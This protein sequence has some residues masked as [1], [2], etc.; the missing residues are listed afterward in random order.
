MKTMRVPIRQVSA[1]THQLKLTTV[2]RSNGDVRCGLVLRPTLSSPS[3]R[4]LIRDRLVGADLSS[5]EKSWDFLT[6]GGSSR[7]RASLPNAPRW[8]CIW[9]VRRALGQQG[10]R[11]VAPGPLE[12]QT[13]TGSFSGSRRIPCRRG[14]LRLV[15]PYGGVLRP[16]EPGRRA[17]QLEEFKRSER[18]SRASGGK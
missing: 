8:P 10:S 3:H 5:R 9:C 17:L 1:L 18:E 7:M 13:R 15:L 6:C 12:V 14:E 2:A 11:L 4:H 16:T